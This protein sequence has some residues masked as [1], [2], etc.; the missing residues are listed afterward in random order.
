MVLIDCVSRMVQGVLPSEEAFSDESHFHGLLDYPQY[1]RP[2][3]YLEKSVPDILLSGHHAN[4]E[5]W[6]FEKRLERTRDRRPDLYEKY[7]RE[8]KG[9]QK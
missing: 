1:T 8:Q 6:R 9:D 7:I 4:I 3:E 2:P 5:K